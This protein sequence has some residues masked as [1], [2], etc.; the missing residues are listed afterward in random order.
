MS[1]RSFRLSEVGASSGSNLHRGGWEAIGRRDG[2][3]RRN[4]VGSNEL[5]R[6]KRNEKWILNF[7]TLLYSSMVVYPLNWWM[8]SE[9]QWQRRSR[10]HRLRNRLPRKPVARNWIARYFLSVIVNCR[11]FSPPKGID[12]AFEAINMEKSEKEGGYRT[13]QL[14]NFFFIFIAYF[15][16]IINLLAFSSILEFVHCRSLSILCGW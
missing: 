15:N 1:V 6:K 2:F 9:T 8:K 7:S 13:S 12:A 16:I 11:R 4:W 10:H 5:V 3:Q 14:A